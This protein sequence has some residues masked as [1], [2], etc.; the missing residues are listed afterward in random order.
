MAKGLND[1]L[2]D[3]RRISEHRHI[4]TDKKINE[5]H[6]SLTKNLNNFLAEQ[7][8]E[9]ADKD[10][11]MFTAYL[12]KNRKK[13]W[14][15]NEIAKNVDGMQPELKKAIMGLVDDT[16]SKCFEGITEAVNKAD[17]A[18]KMAAVAKEL[19]VKP[20]VLKQSVNNNISKLTLPRVLEKNRAEI[21][22]QI[23]QELTI[24]LANGDRYEDMAKRIS[25][26]IG[27][28]EEKAKNITRTETHRNIENGFM[29]G[30]AEFDKT[31]EGSNLIWAVTW[32]TRK[33]LFVRPNRRYKTKK[34]WIT[35]QSGSANHVKMEGVT[36]KAGEM[37]DL[38]DGAKA[39]NPGNSGEARHDCNCR[40][41]LE[42]NLMTVEEFATATNQTVEQVCKK[43][44]RTPTGGVKKD[45]VAPKKEDTSKPKEKAPEK[46]ELKLSDYPD[47]FTKGAEGKNTQ[48][49]IDYINNIDGADPNALKLY[50]STGKLENISSQGIPFKIS[51]GK[52]H[53]IQIRSYGRGGDIAD[54]KYIVPKFKGDN[55]AGQVNT[56]L[57]EQMHLLDMFGRE[58][59]KTSS[60]WF[61]VRNKKLVDTFNN[62]TDEISDEIADL[63]KKHRVEYDATVKKVRK[64]YDDKFESAANE[65]REALVTY[66]DYKKNHNKIYKE[67]LEELDYECRNLMG[68]GIGN[69]QDIYDA[70]SSGT[71]RANGTVVYGHG[72]QY[73]ARVSSQI[74]ETVANYVSLSVT[75][76]DLIEML[77]KDKPDL[78]KA[79]D[80][81][82][83]ELLEK[84][85]VK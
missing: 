82:V 29:D 3:L 68:G 16:Y 27:V 58:D 71:Y 50:A 35:K 24:G 64:K 2:Y 30:E 22:Y 52:D 43:Y 49:L 54:V 41:F 25:S 46:V 42:Y 62:T 81:M 67:M 63:F 5:I 36:V 23:Q 66:K 73:Y 11:R 4:L 45:T 39:T 1:L 51:H 69:L 38:G 40:C 79:L 74:K 76:P 34:G 65:Y 20:E 14:F 31:F 55:I 78:C 7:Y 84:A 77:R 59:V 13:A 48:K 44:N 32:R 57:H 75:R 83:V 80:D 53:A 26:R 9:F 70:L 8:I 85:G 18:E 33:D 6:K 37:F 47:A 12:D 72:Q 17:T 19:R 15:L 28:S 10:G 61:S 21:T 56:T 60:K